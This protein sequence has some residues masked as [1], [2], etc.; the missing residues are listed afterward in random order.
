MAADPKS[1]PVTK[2]G[3]PSHSV[4]HSKPC[5]NDAD[6]RGP[7]MTDPNASKMPMVVY[8][9]SAWPLSITDASK[10]RA[11]MGYP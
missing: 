2:N 7:A 11:S 6:K 10:L 9:T 1:A 4:P 3:N 8:M 5:L